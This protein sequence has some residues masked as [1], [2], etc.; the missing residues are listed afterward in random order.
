[1][2]YDI[3]LVAVLVFFALNGR[4]KGLMMSVF[5]FFSVIISYIAAAL[6][7]KPASEFFKTTPAYGI[8][9]EKV[10]EIVP[11]NQMLLGFAPGSVQEMMAEDAAVFLSN[12]IVSVAIF[13]IVLILMKIVIKI[14]NSVFKLP[15]L[16]FLNKTGGM[17]IGLVTGF[18]I[19]YAALAAW[20]AFA[21]FELPVGM[22]NSTLLKS[23]FENNLLFILIS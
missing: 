19:C 7:V 17:I 15:G 16:N 1:M 9:L 22:E 13:I 21:V 11:Q 20:G 12:V 5:G 14:L 8:L 23:M 10:G 6:L 3:V 18:L 2:I 4:R